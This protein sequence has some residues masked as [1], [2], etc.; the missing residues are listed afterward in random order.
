MELLIMYGNSGFDAG[1]ESD[2]TAMH[3]AASKGSVE[4]PY[5]FLRRLPIC[6]VM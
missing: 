4:V 3:T 2:R 1:S 6:D 5:Q